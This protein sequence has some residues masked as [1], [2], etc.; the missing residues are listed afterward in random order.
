MYARAGM[1][2]CSDDPDDEAARAALAATASTDRKAATLRER[3]R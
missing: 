3:R 2:T 1:R